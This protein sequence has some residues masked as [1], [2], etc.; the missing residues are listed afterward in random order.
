M[1]AAELEDT[2]SRQHADMETY[3]GEFGALMDL[4]TEMAARVVG[5]LRE[6]EARAAA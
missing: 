3:A 4:H 6:Q 2:L 1:T 5:M